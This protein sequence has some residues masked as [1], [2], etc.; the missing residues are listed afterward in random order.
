MSA[1]FC[2]PSP[3]VRDGGWMG[4]RVGGRG[5]VIDQFGDAVMCCKEICG[6][7]WRRRH[8]GVKE[9]I[10]TEATPGSL[11]IDCEVYTLFSNLLPAQLQQ[12][13]GELEWGRARQGVVPDFKI[14]M[15]TQS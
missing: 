12:E 2:L 7:S 6:D 10:V 8:D 15:P 3:A 13:G 4:K 5:E 14:L 9:R 11:S 1:H